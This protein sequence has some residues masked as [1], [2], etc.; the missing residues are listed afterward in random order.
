MWIHTSDWSTHFYSS[1][2]YVCMDLCVCVCVRWKVVVVPVFSE[3]SRHEDV[4]RSRSTAPCI[5]NPGSRRKWTISFTL[6]PL[7]S[8]GKS[9]RYPLN[10]RLG[11]LQRLS[12]SGDEEKKNLFPCRESKP[13]RSVSILVIVLVEISRL[14]CF[15]NYKQVYKK[16][17]VKLSL[18]FNWARRHEGVLEEWSYSSTHS[19]TSEPDGGKWSASRPDRFTPRESAPGTHWIGGWVGS[20]AVLDAVVKRKIPSPRLEWNPRTPIV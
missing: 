18:C 5:L 2:M 4:W 15:T 20:R 10:K 8:L 3:V 16:V 14:I 13:C 7:Y 6:R 11:G 19:L 12:E 17:K 9:P 1:Y